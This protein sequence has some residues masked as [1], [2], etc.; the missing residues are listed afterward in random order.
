MKTI[1]IYSINLLTKMEEESTLRLDKIVGCTLHNKKVIV[2][3]EGHS[4]DLDFT[5]TFYADRAYREI[6]KY[7]ESRE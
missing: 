2:H 1:T 5:E 6:V 7:L 3:F 4:E